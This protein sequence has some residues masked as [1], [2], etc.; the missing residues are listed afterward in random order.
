VLKINV[1]VKSVFNVTDGITVLDYYFP[2][3]FGTCLHNDINLSVVLLSQLNYL[4]N[5]IEENER[6]VLT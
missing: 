1:T 3:F 2:M 4:I 6:Y 5:D